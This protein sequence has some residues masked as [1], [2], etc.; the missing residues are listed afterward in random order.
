MSFDDV[1]QLNVTKLIRKKVHRVIIH[2]QYL[3]GHL[4]WNKIIF[5]AQSNAIDYLIFINSKLF[6]DYNIALLRLKG[7]V[8]TFGEKNGVSPVCL[9]SAEVSFDGWN[10]TSLLWRFDEAGR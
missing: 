2:P 10:A 5:N 4:G 7:P 8:P 3:D 1:D 6:V 9:P